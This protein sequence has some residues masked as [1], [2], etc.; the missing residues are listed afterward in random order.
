ML[1]KQLDV[2]DKAD[3]KFH[4]VKTWLRNNYDTHIA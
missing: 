4:D 3:F 1:E 2:G